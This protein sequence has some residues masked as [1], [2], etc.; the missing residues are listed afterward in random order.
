M[1]IIKETKN[2]LRLYLLGH[3]REEDEERVELRLL[4]DPVFAED[5]DTIVDEI[6]DQYVGK[7][8]PGEERKRVER[9]FLQSAERQQKVRFAGELL[10]RATVERGRT[11]VN[12][13]APPGVG[14]WERASEFWNR[15]T[16]SLR[17]A[18][19]FATLVIL[20]GVAML[21]LP[22]RN[23]TSP[24]YASIALKISSSDRSA[25][26]EIPTIKRQAAD[27]GIRFDL[28]IP[29]GA[30]KANSYRVN[31]TGEQ[32]TRDLQ[33]TE[34]NDQTI[35][36]IVPTV[37]MPPGSY[38]IKLFAVNADATEQPIPGSYL[39]NIE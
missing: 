31:L 34:Q 20:V 16:L 3:L 37:D 7:E 17:F 8:L 25:G 30:P 11:G 18:S 36:V 13:P 2:E 4:T 5:F 39:F 15:Q 22:T 33:V 9:Y 1:L 26:S 21:V 6:T 23:T 29:D 14:W 35:V 19:I 28:S 32:G 27:A 12:V 38:A 24:S 10:R